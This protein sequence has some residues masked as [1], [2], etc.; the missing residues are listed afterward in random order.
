[1]LQGLA[2]YQTLV[3]SDA[4]S[5]LDTELSDRIELYAAS[6]EALYLVSEYCSDHVS[7]NPASAE[8]LRACVRFNAKPPP[9]PD[10]ARDIVTQL[11][12]E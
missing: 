4:T 11:R 5:S 7:D 8:F 3:G 6:P 10:Q 1:L 9:P 2:V 12:G